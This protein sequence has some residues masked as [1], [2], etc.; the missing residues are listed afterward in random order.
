MVAD[1]IEKKGLN[2]KWARIIGVPS[3]AF[4]I[5]LAS[6]DPWKTLP[7]DI[8]LTKIIKNIFYVFLYWEGNRIIFIYLRNRYPNHKDTTKKIIVQVM[9][10]LG[11]VS[12]AAFV[13]AA[14]DRNLS[15]EEHEAFWASYLGIAEKS[16]LFLGIVTMGYECVYFFGK[17][18]KSLYESERL[19][20]EGVISQLE[21]LKNQISPH[22]LFNSLNAL[23][24]LVPEDPQLSVVFIQKLS[25]VYRHVLSHNDKNLVD[26]DVEIHF[27]R[28][29]I[30]LF[31]MRFG[32]N[33]VV[34]Y[35]L[36][37]NVDHL[38]IVPFTLQMLVENA[39]KH[40]VISSKK[41]LK[42][43]IAS[44]SD[45]IIVKN[46]L[47]KKISG[48][49]STNTGLKNIISRYRLLTNRLVDVVADNNEFSVSLPL[50][51]Y[52]TI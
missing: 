37:E 20:K 4:L 48:V 6:N 44:D 23:I 27:L 25:N 21:M 9:F 41:P 50:L 29:Y 45:K 49:E 36:P 16:A 26:L 38:Q 51:T 14:I 46:N 33:L 7:L 11:F 42:I 18:E 47:Q 19:K 10:F 52:Q 5:I 24:T 13:M 17:W 1:Q 32:E 3:L 31:Q 12:V 28:D 40:N 30:F 22:F 2:D 8:Q 43:V 35:Q 34:E 39:V 15:Y